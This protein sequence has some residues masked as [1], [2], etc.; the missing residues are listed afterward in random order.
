MLPPVLIPDNWTLSNA[1]ETE[2]MATRETRRQRG[3]RQ[4]DMIVRRLA[5]ELRTARLTAGLSQEALAELAGWTQTEISRFERNLFTNVSVPRVAQLAAV[6]G[7]DM[8]ATL[9]VFAEPV[10]DRGQQA[11][12]ERFLTHVSPSYRRAREVLL[13]NPGDRRSW[14]LL[15]RLDAQRVGV[16]VETRIRDIQVLVRRI[17]ERERD[18]GVDEILI[19]VSDTAHNRALVAELR[20]ALGSRFATTPRVLLAALRAGAVLPGSGVILV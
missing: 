15:L 19:V 3:R 12:I 20:D 8:S 11:A 4:G 7:L 6:V 2:R 10:A 18:G 16:E 17:R 5:T 9:H 13:P 1:S 14:D